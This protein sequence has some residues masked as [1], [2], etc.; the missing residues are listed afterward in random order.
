MD[1]GMLCAHHRFIVD[2]TI[3][4]CSRTRATRNGVAASPYIEPYRDDGITL[5]FRFGMPPTLGAVLSL[6][7]RVRS[8]RIENN[9]II[10]FAVSR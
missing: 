4:M 2:I 8:T 3:F 1:R 5:A 7:S 10:Y 9:N 6:G